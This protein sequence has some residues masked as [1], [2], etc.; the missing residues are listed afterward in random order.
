MIHISPTQP[1]S[2]VQIVEVLPGEVRHGVK[3]LLSP[4]SKHPMPCDPSS[5][6]SISLGFFASVRELLCTWRLRR[7][8]KQLHYR[9]ALKTSRG[10][11]AAA[12]KPQK[13]QH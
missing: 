2:V 3:N 11:I 13:Q 9:H 4:E 1:L 12:V 10:G 6:P 5:G 7:P 8:H